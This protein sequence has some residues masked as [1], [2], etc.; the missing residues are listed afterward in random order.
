MPDVPAPDRPV[1]REWRAFRAATPGLQ[2]FLALTTVAALV[3]PWLV[4]N[5]LDESSSTHQLLTIAVLVAV[6]VLNV[7]V[8]RSLT[9][10]LERTH[11]PHKALS[12]WA[13]A[14]ALLLPTQWLL[15]L[16]PLTYA[17][18]WWRGM[19]I[20]L[21]KWIGSAGFLVLS[22][23]FAQWVAMSVMGAN[24]NYMTGAG[25]R[26]LVAILLATLA[27][28]GLEALL[29][30][31]PATLNHP[32]DEVWLQATLRSSSFYGTEAVVLIIGALF[33]AVWTGGPWF[34]LL[35]VPIYLIAQ[36]AALHEPLRQ[37]AESAVVLS[38]QNAELEQ[39]NQFQSDLMAMLGH[40]IG[41]PLTSV[42]GYTEVGIEALD[43]GDT[44]FAREALGIVDRAA[45]QVQGVLND[46]LALVASDRR[47]LVATPE[48]TPLAPRLQ[49]AA[50]HQPPQGRPT[51]DCP[52]DLAAYVQPSHLDQMVANLLSNARKYAGGATRIAAS[53]LDE[54]TVEITV[55]D[56][57]PGI[58][59]TF[60]ADLF[61]RFTRAAAS[62][63]G[64]RGTGLGLF[65]TRELARANSGTVELC[66]TGPTG[67]V[68]AIRVPAAPSAPTAPPA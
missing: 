46:V 42:M 62:A 22:G 15:V 48:R 13:L 40:E 56:E 21:W 50:A 30:W 8:G 36:R 39:A 2:A 66:E 11:Q 38:E 65:I 27:F 9:G 67:S 31:G 64:I 26:G 17:H 61:E 10:G 53:R 59:D 43:S 51:V 19:R 4:V 41:N 49:A 16:V 12:A 54:A 35:T 33:S 55:T 45:N 47:A 58:P 3:V 34:V 5:A 23:C 18:T 68:F 7:E 14:T 1:I 63:R 57:G 28:L 37:R 29:F 25:G 44:V 32:E 20:R 6:S 24:I 52:D 60:R